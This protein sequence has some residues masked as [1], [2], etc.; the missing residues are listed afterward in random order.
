MAVP[1]TITCP[2]CQATNPGVARFCMYCG[3]A[4]TRRC[5]ACR[6]LVALDTR[7]CPSCGWVLTTAAP[8]PTAVP[9]R[10]LAGL[11]S[12]MVGRTTEL[13]IL[14]RLSAGL[15]V[16]VGRA[17]LIT[18][19]PGLG[20]SRL[21]A[22]WQA[23]ARQS[24]GEG[25]QWV[26]ARCLPYGQEVAYHLL[27]ALVRAVLNL[28]TT[29]GEPETHAALDK[30]SS[31]LADTGLPGVYPMLGHL[32]G[33]PPDNSP[34]DQMS[35]L[36]PRVLQTRYLTALRE[37]LRGLAHSHPLVLILEDVHWADPSSVELL[38][39]LLPLTT[40]L[41]LIFCIVSRVERD[42][43]GWKLVTAVRELSGSTLIE[44]PL[45][46]LSPK[47]SQQLVTNLLARATMP[48]HL[49]RLILEKADGNPFFMEEII[50][51]LIDRGILVQ[52]NGAWSIETPIER[53]D[54][55]DTLQGLLLAR[56]CC[57]P[58][59]IQETLRVAAI[60]GR[61]FSVKVLAQVL[62]NEALPELR[63]RLVALEAAGLLQLVTE[64]ADLEY[65]FRHA[66]MQEA[67]Y[68]PL[69][70]EE[71]ARLHLAVGQALETLY[72]EQHD[73][74]APELARHFAAAG[75]CERALHYT[76]LAGDVALAA[77][78]NQEAEGHYCA[79]LALPCAASKRGVVCAGLGRALAR[80]SRYQEAIAFWRMGI[81]HYQAGGKTDMVARLYAFA[82]R[83]AWYANDAAHGLQLCAEGLAA[84]ADAPESP[85]LA[86]L[87][88]EAG[89]AY[90]F[91][92]MAEPALRLCEQALEMAERLQAVDVQADTLSTIGILCDLPPE[93]ALGALQRAVDLAEEAGMLGIAAR[94]HINMCWTLVELVGDLAGAYTHIE[95]ALTLTRRQGVA[96]EEFLEL[97]SLAEVALMQGAFSTA[98]TFLPMLHQ[99]LPATPRP[100]REMRY[101]Q[102]L[103]AE[104]CFCRGHWQEAAERFRLLQTSSV[105][106]D[107][108]KF[109]IGVDLHL[110]ETLLE[111][112]AWEEAEQ[113]LHAARA[114][115]E[116]ALP[117][118]RREWMGQL[119]CRMLLRRG[120]TD[121]VR[122][123]LAAIPDS[124]S[125]TM[126]MLDRV[127]WR[128]IEAHL[129]AAE[130]QWSRALDSFAN[131]VA[132]I[133]QMGMRWRYARVLLDWAAVYQQ[134]GEASDL[135]RVRSL[136]QEALARFTELDAPGYVALTRERLARLD[137]QLYG[138]AVAHQQTSRELSMAAAIQSGLLPD[139]LPALPGW[140][141]AAALHPARETAG[142][143]YDCIALPEGRLAIVVADVVDKGLGAALYMALG[144][145]LIRTYASDYPTQPAQVVAATNHRLVTDTPGNLFITGFY[146]VL[147]P[148]TG[149]LDYCNAGHNPPYL[150]RAGS[151][152]L[153]VP[154][155]PTGMLLGVSAEGLWEQATVQ[156]APGDRLVLYTD[157]V[158]EA[159]N[160]AGVF[161]GEERLLPIL[162]SMGNLA[163]QAMLDALMQAL[164]AFVGA[165]PRYDDITIMVVVREGQTEITDEQR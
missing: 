145:T 106:H 112:G 87:I 4:L 56:I 108:P 34:R 10:G 155:P 52:Q 126:V 85:G 146:G 2:S 157:G 26:E 82:G 64:Y 148:A 117:F 103:E 136:L 124:L 58:V 8:P 40:E 76:L 21:V 35:I 88:H 97:E 149:H 102:L 31:D 20:K 99:L 38:S 30:L 93:R 107:D 18:G 11:A 28:P 41:P 74:L 69:P 7:R 19:D 55:P 135:E 17:V 14:L 153:L 109:P 125:R 53:M 54:I 5:P 81:E 121:E 95:R 3:T 140:Q 60:I 44:L 127:E 101:I 130:K 24:V 138:Q 51:M 141:F 147:D 96:A 47:E 132:T 23:A 32:L 62:R 111:L 59:G 143:F 144:R 100:E 1:E 66:L 77:F 29:A 131:L 13:A 151:E 65:R 33:L 39:K 98:E 15:Q 72:A 89:R 49:H 164:D 22:E 92:D 160:Q 165:A 113:A 129:Y 120:Q 25:C 37:L 78:A 63:S 45:A 105:P 79:A 119:Q 162:R 46:A 159:Q 43:P 137:A 80:Q 42:R 134:C 116:Q 27:V 48:H 68:A 142:D 50:R 16:G 154:L 139:D 6:A 9:V 158:I 163:A 84:V 110:A 73:E 90:H 161:F 150:L 86:A 57:L 61:Q 152:H 94:A 83:A 123:I 156:L 118:Y 91:N 71:R 128:L 115:K 122:R 133:E 67:A 12:P 114:R 70:A 36:E 104:L 75:A